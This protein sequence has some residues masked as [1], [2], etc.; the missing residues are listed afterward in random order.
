MQAFNK[1]CIYPVLKICAGYT[2]QT[3]IKRPRWNSIF[4]LPDKL[5]VCETESQSPD[6]NLFRLFFR[7][8]SANSGVNAFL[9][10]EYSIF[11]EHENRLFSAFVLT[12]EILIAIQDTNFTNLTIR[13][14]PLNI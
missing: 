13:E 4:L 3:I 1:S 14:F 5:L 6:V 12:G 10:R 2:L 8:L 9:T 11:V 7:H